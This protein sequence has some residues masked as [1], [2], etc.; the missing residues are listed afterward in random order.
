MSKYGDEI[1]EIILNST[2]HPTAEQI[3]MEMKKKILKS[4][5][6]AYIII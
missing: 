3:F 4:C 2:E 6:R 5:R 1:L